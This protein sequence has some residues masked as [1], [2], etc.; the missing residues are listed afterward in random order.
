MVNDINFYSHGQVIPG[1]QDDLYVPH[2]ARPARNRRVAIVGRGKTFKDVPWNDEGLSLWAFNDWAMTGK[3]EREPDALF[4]MHI[5]ALKTDRYSD[6]Y[7][8]WLM[9]DHPFPIWMHAT[10]DRVPACKAYPLSNI[11]FLY[12]NHVFRGLDEVKHFYTSTTCYAIAM[13]LWQGYRRIELYGIDLLAE[14]EYRGHRDAVFFWLGKATG[15]G[16]DVQVSGSSMLFQN[17]RY[18]LE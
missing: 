18:G 16:I 12:C 10:D 15:M 14:T 8:A 1:K 17:V 5:D 13:A 11:S 9:A 3:F 2:F 4:E 6:E 7:K